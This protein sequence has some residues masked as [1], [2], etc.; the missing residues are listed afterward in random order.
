MFYRFCSS[1]YYCF[2]SWQQPSPLDKIIFFKNVSDSLLI[3]DVFWTVMY[4]PHLL[5]D[6]PM[7]FDVFRTLVCVPHRFLIDQ[8][9]VMCFETF[10]V[11]TSFLACP[12]VVMCFDDC[13]PTS[14]LDHKT[15][16][17]SLEWLLTIDMAS[18]SGF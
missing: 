17:R 1:T 18:V 15:Y 11:S 3:E 2:Y 9:C 7:Y 12:M 5:S 4:V 14:L 16:E 6:C 8:C 10:F 13:C